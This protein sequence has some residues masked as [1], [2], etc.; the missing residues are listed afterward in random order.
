MHGFIGALP[1]FLLVYFAFPGCVYTIKTIGYNGIPEVVSAMSAKAPAIRS[2]KALASVSM[3]L[4]DNRTSF[5]EAVVIS[6]TAIRLE[7]LNIFYQPVFIVVYNNAVA[8]LDV[9]TGACSLSPTA[10]GLG[11]YTRINVSAPVFEALITGRLPGNPEKMRYA[12]NNIL[13]S[14]KTDALTWS[15]V[16]GN[17]LMIRTLTVIRNPSYSIICSYENYKT[18]NAVKIPTRVTCRWLGNSINIH[19]MSVRINTPVDSALMN[20]YKLCNGRDAG[21]Q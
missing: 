6:G 18:Y 14:G 7:T 12:E 2:I 9:N 5:P 20:T 10:K 17:N 4:D 3:K 15:A 16:I 13:L 21:K 19:Y 11:R 8:A 1:L